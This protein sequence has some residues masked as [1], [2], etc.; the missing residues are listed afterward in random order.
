MDSSQFCLPKYR[1]RQYQQLSTN[2]VTGANTESK[3]TTEIISGLLDQYKLPAKNTTSNNA[4]IPDSTKGPSV[5]TNN[6]NTS[7]VLAKESSPTNTAGRNLV[8][9]QQDKIERQKPKYIPF[10]H[11]SYVTLTRKEISFLINI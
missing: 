7:P 8:Q 4:K 5:T 9:N 2:C 1:K 3:N 10:V 11:D 6:S